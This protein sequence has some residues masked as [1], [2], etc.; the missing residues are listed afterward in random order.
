MRNDRFARWP[1]NRSQLI[2]ISGLALLLSGSRV[3]AEPPCR[4][5][6]LPGPHS[7]IPGTRGVDRSLASWDSDGEGP[8]APLLVVGG[9]LTFAGGTPVSNIA[10]WD[11]NLRHGAGEW[12]TFGEGFDGYVRYLTSWDPDGE[13]EASPLLVASGQFMQSGSVPTHRIAVWTP[14]RGL[15]RGRWLQMGNGLSGVPILLQWDRDGD[16][17]SPN[18]LVA[19]GPFSQ[20]RTDDGAD[21]DAL[22]N[23]W[24][25]TEWVP[26]STDGTSGY[27]SP[28]APSAYSVRSAITWDP[29]GSGPMDTEIVIAGLF[30][31]AGDVRVNHIGAWSAGEKEGEGRWRDFAGGTDRSVLSIAAWDH[32]GNQATADLILALGIFETAGGVETP[33]GAAVWD[34]SAK[35]G[36]G[37]WRRAPWLHGFNFGLNFLG[38]VDPDGKG[39]LAPRMAAA[40]PFLWDSPGLGHRLGW[41]DLEA[42]EGAGRWRPFGPAYQVRVTSVM[43]WDQDGEGPAEPAHIF[44]G[45]SAGYG[46]TRICSI[47]TGGPDL[48][49]TTLKPI[50]T[51][52]VGFPRSALTWDHDG[53]DETLDQ[54]VVAGSF[55]IH[56]QS[57]D[58]FASARWEPGPT[59]NKA[60]WMSMGGSLSSSFDRLLRWDVGADDSTGPVIVALGSLYEDRAEG[61]IRIGYKEPSTDGNDQP[62]KPLGGGVLPTGSP[63]AAATW[64]TPADGVASQRLVLAGGYDTRESG[65]AIFETQFQWIDASRRDDPSGWMPLGQPLTGSAY[66]MTTLRLAS[67]GIEEE[68]PIAG[69]DL[70][71]SNDSDMLGVYRWDRVAQTWVPLTGSMNGAARALCAWDPDESGPLDEEL[72]A[73]GDFT[74]IDGIAALRVARWIPSTTRGDGHWE[75]MGNGVNARLS[76]LTVWDPDGYGAQHRV[77]VGTGSDS[78]GNALVR[79]DRYANLSD[80]AWAQFFPGPEYRSFAGACS[81][82][83]DG[84]GILAPRLIVTGDF[85]DLDDRVSPYIGVFGRDCACP[86]DADGDHVVAFADI[87]IMLNVWGQAYP[88]STGLGDASR[89]GRVDFGDLMAILANYGLDCR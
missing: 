88:I 22:R 3:R 6:W 11:P 19:I 39:P 5:E 15:D 9:S 67:A 37:E 17:P 58:V 49:D 20:N 76:S 44:A 64:T 60:R 12:I 40:H 62:W 8:L 24:T 48:L 57:S 13:G 70:R 83:P 77:L 26:T 42:D 27:W 35:G 56:E 41:L 50:G 74:E 29:D 31:N 1:G 32:D 69:G 65:T 87:T 61:P 71:P 45:D 85:L 47:D 4:D 59:E 86:G 36:E 7:E 78:N 25:L 16:G 43:E 30:V 63:L 52:A 10:A 28:I 33:Y 53:L 34:Q 82:D 23:L 38:S 21:D 46:V 84:E 2:L 54:L 72:V 75:P 80:G 68:V 89:D 14:P 79:W 51:G 55:I 66:A 81:W 73:A 18:Q